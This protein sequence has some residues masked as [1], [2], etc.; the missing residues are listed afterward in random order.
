[1]F[2]LRHLLQFLVASLMM[3]GV[4][5]KGLTRTFLENIGHEVGS[6]LHGGCD[7]VSSLNQR[8]DQGL[9]S[10]VESLADPAK[11]A[12]EQ[13][14]D[15]LFKNQL[16]P[17]LSRIDSLTEARLGQLYMI[18]EGALAKAETA[19]ANT[20]ERVKSEIILTAS[21][22]IQ[23]IIDEVL[24]DV[25]C[26]IFVTSAE[27]QRFVD[28]NLTLFGNLRRA[29]G[30]LFNKCDSVDQ[31]NWYSVYLGRKCQYDIQIAGSTAVGSLRNSYIEYLEF[32]SRS[33]CLLSS[34]QAKQEVASHAAEYAKRLDLWSLALK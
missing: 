19:T 12:F 27:A 16:D 33:I 7:V 10:K 3:I 20:I 14:A 11:E 22:E 25:K 23:K 9:S 30:N 8:F 4:P 2:V 24:N 18:F 31:N 5:A 34:P 32:S 28:T 15:Y 13:A 6:C 1:M 26:A 29:V 21:E 17:F